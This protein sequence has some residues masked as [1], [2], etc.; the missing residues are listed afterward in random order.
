MDLDDIVR[1][2][3]TELMLDAARNHTRLQ[4]KNAAGDLAA[5]NPD[6]GALS[7]AEFEALIDRISN[8]IETADITIEITEA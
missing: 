8:A 3:A 4:V 6:V 1:E 7:D 2:T 5:S